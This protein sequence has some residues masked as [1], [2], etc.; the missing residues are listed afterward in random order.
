M[1]DDPFP[2]A[3]QRLGHGRRVP[4]DGRR[5][6]KKRAFLGEQILGKGPVPHVVRAI[7]AEDEGILAMMGIAQSAGQ[8]VAAVPQRLDDHFIARPDVADARPDRGH[9]AA[10]LVPLNRGKGHIAAAAGDRLVVGGANA[11]GFHADQHVPKILRLRNRNL[12]EPQ[13]VEIVQDRRQ[14]GAHRK[15]F[16]CSLFGVGLEWAWGQTGIRD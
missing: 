8:T 9:D 15:P 14:H 6:G 10:G 2:R 3:R 11:A 12:L 7:A 13:I 16:R 5:L 1:R 4:R